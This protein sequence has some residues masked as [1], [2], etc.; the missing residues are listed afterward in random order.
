[1]FVSFCRG[2]RYHDRFVAHLVLEVFVGPR[3]EGM[4]ACHDPDSNK[5]NNHRSNLRWDTHSANCADAIR[6]GEF[7]RGERQGSSKL[8]ESDVITIIRNPDGVSVADLA[9]RFGCHPMHIHRI[10]RRQQ[11]KHLVLQPAT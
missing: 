2:G 11:W 8:S 3:P 5:H 7:Q 6:K 9:K 1:M 4:E 10:R